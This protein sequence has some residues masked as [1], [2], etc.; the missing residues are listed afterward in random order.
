MV[1][2]TQDTLPHSRWFQRCCKLAWWPIIFKDANEL[3]TKCDACQMK[4]NINKRNEI[5]HN[6]ILQVEVFDCWKIDFIGTFPPSYGNL[7]ILVAVKYVFK[8]IESIVSSTNDAK[9]V[10]KIFKPFDFSKVQ[11]SEVVI[12]DGGS[13]FINKLFK[14]LWRNMVLSTR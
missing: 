14:N 8:W 5:P 10:L 3:V 2:V 1:L 7:Y 12:S 4:G 13:H 9:V 6:F 11:C